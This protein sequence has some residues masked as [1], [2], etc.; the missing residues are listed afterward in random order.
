MYN[1]REYMK[2]KILE[3]GNLK[4]LLPSAKIFITILLL[5]FFVLL[6]LFINK[7]G[8]D[9]VSQ[10]N[11]EL[12]SSSITVSE[13][14]SIDS[15]K[16]GVSDWEEKLWG[17]DPYQKV[18][19]PDGVSDKDY[20]EKKRQEQENKDLTDLS[21]KPE[22]TTD[23][24]TS[25]MIATILALSEAGGEI[26]SEELAKALASSSVAQIQKEIAPR[27]YTRANFTIVGTSTAE[28]SEYQ[29]T[30]Q[31]VFT[32]KNIS[33]I[34]RGYGLITESL[35]MDDM[36]TLAEATSYNK[37]IETML[38]L[39]LNAKVPYVYIEKHILLANNLSIMQKATVSTLTLKADPLK[40]TALYSS[41]S[42]A[43]INLMNTLASFNAQ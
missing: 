29:K 7:K 26:K 4:R 33:D 2:T 1:I 16:D 10:K 19:N 40:G 41:Y 6:L 34:A 28:I 15:D 14:G 18:S 9:Y 30:L 25:Q 36:E 21:K 39:L 37:K 22:T 38:G 17:T 31:A 35:R 20:V 42:N 32:E 3:P 13:V 27:I 43:L 12:L 24:I 11:K 8:G 5:T 23:K